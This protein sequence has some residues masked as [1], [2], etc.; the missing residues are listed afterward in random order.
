[1]KK[2]FLLKSKE[3]GEAVSF[4]KLGLLFFMLLIS[5]NLSAQIDV[6]IDQLRNMPESQLLQYYNAA[7]SQGYSTEQLIELARLKGA[8]PTELMELRRRINELEAPKKSDD[9]MDQKDFNS[10]NVFALHQFHY[11]KCPRPC[12]LFLKHLG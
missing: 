5:I 3:S 7:K 10:E 8:S 1:M 11:L 2:S 6:S 9:S 4:F 12:L